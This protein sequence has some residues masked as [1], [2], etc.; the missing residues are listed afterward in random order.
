MSAPA[1]AKGYD[2]ELLKQIAAPFAEAFKPYVHGAFGMPKENTVADALAAN[3]MYYTRAGGNRIAG[4]ALVKRLKSSSRQIDFAGRALSPQAGDIII[5]AIAGSDDARVRIVDVLESLDRPAIWVEDFIEAPHSALWG[6]LGYELAGV[7]VMASSDLKGLW[8][9]GRMGPRLPAPLHRADIPALATIDD[10]FIFDDMLDAALAEISAYEASIGAEPWA[11]HYSNYNKRQSWTAFAL[12]GF[13]ASDPSFI[14]KPAEMSKQ[15]KKDN[16]ARMAA[17]C[18]DT[19]AYQ[20]FPIIRKIVESLPGQSQRIRLMRLASGNGELTRHADIV[21]PE[22]GTANGQTCRIHIPL[23]S[24]PECKFIGWGLDGQR[25]EA[26][27]E[28]GTACYLD[29]RKPH[30]VIN[31]GAIDRIHLVIDQYSSDA[32]RAM[33]AA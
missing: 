20:H 6:D 23:Q 17:R 19:S 28:V 21:D 7:K 13:D 31:G 2:V 24:P 33:I 26:R 27:F 10:H 4:S 30:S 1:W 15:W 11:Q 18:D 8:I 12:R 29:T 25:H 22:A 16:P 32:L 3:E 14:I 9:K 5:R